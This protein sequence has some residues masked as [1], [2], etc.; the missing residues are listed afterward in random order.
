MG[1]QSH[2][3]QELEVFYKTKPTIRLDWQFFS[4]YQGCSRKAGFLGV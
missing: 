1:A 3:K 2:A 4:N